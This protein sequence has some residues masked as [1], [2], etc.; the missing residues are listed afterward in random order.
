MTINVSGAGDP[1]GVA[2]RVYRSLDAA[3]HRLRPEVAAMSGFA[4]N[5]G[6]MRGTIE[7]RAPR[8]RS[9]RGNSGVTLRCPRSLAPRVR[10]NSLSCWKST[11]RDH[12]DFVAHHSLDG[13]TKKPPISVAGNSAI[14]PAPLPVGAVFGRRRVVAVLVS[15]VPSQGGSPAKSI[16]PANAPN[17]HASTG[18]AVGAGGATTSTPR[19]KAVASPKL[20][21]DD[22]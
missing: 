11:A 10:C 8:E 14:S 22:L 18:S 1:R 15:F 6:R 13:R 5:C 17:R 2:D 4:H 19:M 21:L 7:C 9:R 3:F 16:A 20:L 12:V